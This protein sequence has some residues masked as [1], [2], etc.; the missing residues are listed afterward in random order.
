LVLSEV[1]I[2]TSS[3]YYRYLQQI[4]RCGTKH[5]FNP[6]DIKAYITLLLVKTRHAYS[7]PEVLFFLLVYFLHAVVI[8]KIAQKL[9]SSAALLAFIP[10]VNVVFLFKL[11]KIPVPFAILFLLIPFANV[12]AICTV[13]SSLLKMI[14]R[15]GY[16][17]WLL[18]IPGVNLIYLSYLA[19]TL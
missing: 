12:V 2:N 3:A 15:S 8:Y 6:H 7:L 11:A 9:N 13:W 19:I 14:G 5:D 17:V 1:A 4:L 16:E 10:I 18:I